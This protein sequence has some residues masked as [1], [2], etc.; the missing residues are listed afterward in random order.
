MKQKSNQIDFDDFPNKQI[1]FTGLKKRRAN[2]E[3]LHKIDE[4][5]LY[6]NLLHNNVWF[7]K[8][9]PKFQPIFDK[10]D[11]RINHVPTVLHQFLFPSARKWKTTKTEER[12]G[13]KYL[14]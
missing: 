3:L 12:Q 7:W 4:N 10:S 2:R 6:G 5:S 9:T 13:H 14:L 1:I 11:E 8:E